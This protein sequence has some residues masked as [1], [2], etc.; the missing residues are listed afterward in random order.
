MTK[1]K[2]QQWAEKGLGLK[3]YHKDRTWVL[4]NTTKAKLYGANYGLTSQLWAKNG[5]LWPLLVGNFSLF[6]GQLW[7]LL[8]S[9]FLSFFFFFFFER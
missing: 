4:N 9:F 7:P 3:Q 2:S 8:I 1:Y 6:C 5:Q